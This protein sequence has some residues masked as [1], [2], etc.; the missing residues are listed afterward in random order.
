MQADKTLAVLLFH[1]SIQSKSEDPSVFNVPTSNSPLHVDHLSAS[2]IHCLPTSF[3]ASLPVGGLLL[4]LIGPAVHN[5]RKRRG[6]VT[7][8]TLVA[9]KKKRR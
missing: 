5:F 2:Q 4:E 9:R 8:A 7:F 3:H 1:S 6:M